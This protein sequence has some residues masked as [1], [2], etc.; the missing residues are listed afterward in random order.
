MG[1]DMVL[2]EHPYV[3]AQKDKIEKHININN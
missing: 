2:W 1:N 3:R